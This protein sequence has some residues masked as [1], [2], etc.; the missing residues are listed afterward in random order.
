MSLPD[1]HK[2]QKKISEESWAASIHA[3]LVDEFNQHM[4]DWPHTPE[5]RESEWLHY[6]F[7]TECA[8]QLTFNFEKPT[9]HVC[10]SCGKVFSG[11][12]YDQTWVK[13]LY[14]RILANMERAAILAN[15]CTDN[16][17][18]TDYI[19]RIFLFYV[20]HYD[21]FAVHG[22]KAGVG[23]VFPQCLSEAIFVIRMERV[24][25]FTRG[26]N[27]FSAQEIE[28]MKQLFFRPA[29]E[30]LN[31]Q[32]RKI[33]N[34]RC[35]ING[36]LAAAANVLDDEELLREAIDSELGWHQQLEAGCR[37][38]GMWYEIAPTYHFYTMGALMSIV[39]VAKDRGI[40]L[41][42][43]SLLEKMA[44][45]PLAFVYENGRFPAYNDGWFNIRIEN[46]LP[47]YEEISALCDKPAISETLSRYY[48]A[49]SQRNS[50]SAL[51]YGQATLAEAPRPTRDSTL[52]EDSGIAIL[53]NDKVRAGMKF[54][55]DGGGH[56]HNDKLA[57]DI[58]TAGESIA[59]DVGT[60]G[61]GIPLTESWS[62]APIAHNMVTIN[63]TG[64]KHCNAELVSWNKSTVTVRCNEAY[65]GV[66]LERSLTL[67]DA[68]LQDTFTV[69]CANHS[70]IDWA[71]HCMGTFEA[72]LPLVPRGIVS[73]AK[74]YCKLENI[75]HCITDSAWSATWTH[76]GTLLTLNAK[77]APNTEIIVA[78]CPGHNTVE[79]L[80]M[81]I[82]R[83]IGTEAIFHCT[84][85]LSI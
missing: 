66:C 51:L 30:F 26:L 77:G 8:V 4:N 69:T 62:Q 55:K 36:A 61:Y 44:L 84:H 25:R 54:T 32:L 71:F 33:H 56:D 5:V 18:Y 6:Y 67:K 49:P 41:F 46:Q 81:V 14:N 83:R 52:F 10:P 59:Y 16:Q 17:V 24:L 68:D 22:D 2:V 50:T 70:T 40:D 63:E 74:G 31:P 11:R 3:K 35:W 76:N 27:L 37:T 12:P 19:R 75:T 45:A 80:K 20:Y 47:L 64:Q 53:Q 39:W 1:W 34:I 78:D 23:K 85:R 58:Y 60:A 38:D 82:I 57:I 42:S 65:D 72:T 28:D 29:A 7:C 13:F 21:Q 79:M 43:G 73:E 15:L 9:A 48:T